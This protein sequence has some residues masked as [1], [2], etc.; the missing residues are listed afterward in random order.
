MSTRL[1]VAWDGDWP[2]VH[3]A[4]DDLESFLWVLLWALVHTLKEFGSTSRTVNRLVERFSSYNLLE[5]MMRESAIVNWQDVVFKGLVWE[6]FDISQEAR[7]A[8]RQHSSAV[9]HFESGDDVDLQQGAWE[10]LEKYCRTVYLEFI[11]A[12]HKHLESIRRYPDWKAVVEANAG[13]LN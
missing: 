1:L 4:I 9:T 7:S 3:T 5:V 13:S 8:L 11:R 2:T 6:W 12:G 10:W